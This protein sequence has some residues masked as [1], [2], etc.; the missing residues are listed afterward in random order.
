[1]S[2]FAALAGSVLRHK[3][4]LSVPALALAI[5]AFGLI[6][7]PADRAVAYQ[8][9]GAPPCIGSINDYMRQG[10]SRDQG[11]GPQAS[12]MGA[13]G[14]GFYGAPSRSRSQMNPAVMGAM[15]IALWALQRYQERHQ[16]HAMRNYRRHWR[17]TAN[18]M[19]SPLG[20]GF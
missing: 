20:Y 5:L 9:P 19:R 7:L 2:I 17:G 3:R 16:R 13:G 6:P 18:P 10:Q 11:Y 4:Q 12:Y 14:Q 15:V 1:M 8:D